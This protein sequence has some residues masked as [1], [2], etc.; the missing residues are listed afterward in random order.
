VKGV[1]TTWMSK[2]FKT[3]S[4]Q[5]SLSKMEVGSSKDG[6]GGCLSGDFMNVVIRGE[7]WKTT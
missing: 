4:N 2:F 7:W 5:Q 6:D 1:I 3:H